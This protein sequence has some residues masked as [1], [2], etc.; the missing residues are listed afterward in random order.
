MKDAN[1]VARASRPLWRER[2]A[3]ASGRGQD[4]LATAV[5]TPALH[6][7]NQLQLLCRAPGKHAVLAFCRDV[8]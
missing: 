5:E 3:R 7:Y 8:K 4:A 2:P 6:P 1:V